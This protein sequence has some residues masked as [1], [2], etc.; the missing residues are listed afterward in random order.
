MA[1]STSSG[2]EIVV[3]LKNSSIDVERAQ[4]DELTSEAQVT[5][6]HKKRRMKVS[7]KYS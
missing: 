7:G 5:Q 3:Q 1:N 6:P 4:E 2:V